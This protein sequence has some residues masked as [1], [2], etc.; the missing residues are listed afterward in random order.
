[1]SCDVD[2]AGDAHLRVCGV[3]GDQV[4]AQKR[5][6]EKNC[7]KELLRPAAALERTGSSGCHICCC[8]GLLASC[9]TPRGRTVSLDIQNEQQHSPIGLDN[10]QVIDF[11]HQSRMY[12]FESSIKVALI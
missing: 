9:C 10:S 1:M 11:M 2:N 4:P 7:C 5:L 6:L 12:A 8:C 3:G